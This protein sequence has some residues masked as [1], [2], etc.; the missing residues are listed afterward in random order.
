MK[1]WAPKEK[2]VLQKYFT[3]TQKDIFGL[4]NLPEV[5]KGTLF[6]RYSRSGKDLRRLFLDEFWRQD[7]LQHLLPPSSSYEDLDV[8]RAEDFYE[9][10][11]IG[12]G[13]DSVAEL[14]GAHIALENISVLATKP[15]EEH[16]LG[17]SF[18]E[19]STR[20]V[21]FDRRDEKGRYRYYRPPEIRRA[22]LLR[23][24]Q[25]TADNLFA[26]Y[27]QLVHDLQPALRRL[28]PGDENDPAYRFSIRAKACDLSRPLL[29]LATLTNMGI[30][31]NGRAFEYLI[32]TLL[33]HPLAE[34]RQFSQLMNQELRKIIPA[35][36][37]RATNEK[38]Q[39]YRQYLQKRDRRLQRWQRHWQA[40]ETRERVAVRLIDFDRRAEEKVLRAIAYP[41]SNL[42]L[43]QLKKKIRQ[44]S[45]QQRRRL[46]RDYLA[47]RQ[48]R[49]HKPGRALEEAYFSFEISADWGVYKDLMRHR[50]LTRHHQLFT[51]QHGYRISPYL[52]A[53]RLAAPYRR[54]MDQA[55][56]AQAQ[57]ARKLPIV[58]QYLVTHGAINRF[59]LRLNL[60]E[61]VHLVELRSQR[62]GHPWYRRVAQEI[63]RQIKARL[64]LLGDY[65]FPFLDDH[66]YDLER[67]AAFQKLMAKA[68]AKGV[69]ALPED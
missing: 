43:R 46:F 39:Q 52:R 30:F 67:L 28:F 21:Y 11:L 8:A 57:I 2:A 10:V 12:Y 44:L 18:L 3:N 56:E 60:R 69:N 48:T 22:G 34:V 66:D 64:P 13:D 23:L 50:V 16:R 58:S 4:V 68:Q 55:Q 19:K 36:V 15:F 49:F 59:Y 20:Y 42:P 17:L 31:G 24:Y 9:R 63:G 37:K 29:P 51:N 32:T 25:E 61:A 54:A 33:A 7:Q 1:N 6:S 40:T 14:G 38:G 47:D 62:Q 5:I 41:W 35:F 65:L 26:T 27:S 45:P 53:A